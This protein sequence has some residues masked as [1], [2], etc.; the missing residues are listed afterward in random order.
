[1][2]DGHGN[3]VPGIVFHVLFSDARREI[4]R[5]FQAVQSR[6]GAV[7]LKVVR[8]RDFAEDAFS[9]VAGRFSEY[10]RG[11]PFKVEFHESI[12]PH[13][14]SGKHQ[15]IIVER[16]DALQHACSPLRNND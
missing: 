6:D 2:R 4:V 3:V 5:Q 13:Q 16:D 7:V 8:G 12:G 1:M 14:G 11:L 9:S 10:L 15:T